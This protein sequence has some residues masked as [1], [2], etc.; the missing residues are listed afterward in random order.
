G[1]L[2]SSMHA[3][4]SLHL[5]SP[6]GFLM[7]PVEWLHSLSAQRVTLSALPNFGMAYLLK[8]LAADEECGID[9]LLNC[10]LDSLRRI[11]VGSDAIDAALA[12][13]FIRT[14]APTGLP[15]DALTPCYG[16]AEAVLMVSC[17]VAG[18]QW[19]RSERQQ[20]TQYRP[21]VSV[22][23]VLP[24]F[25]IRIVH[26]DGSACA[27]SEDGQILLRGGTLASSYFEGPA[28]TDA[29]GFYHSGDLGYLEAGQ[30]Y[31][32]GRS[33]ERIKIDGQSF[34]LPHLES[35]LQTHP[36]LRPGGAA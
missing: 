9:P 10:R 16:M 18:Q 1:A 30:L 14:L 19:R 35:C 28:L 6:A 15:T 8:R 7:N 17:K 26:D 13:R 11:Y 12:S 31:I 21:Q 34:F 29:Q 2:L 20:R 23:T 5:D 3:G 36:E 24:D 32:S 27:E 4:H 22:G 25:E 33:G